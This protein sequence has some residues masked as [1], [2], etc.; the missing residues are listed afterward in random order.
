MRLRVKI[1][2]PESAGSVVDGTLQVIPIRGGVFRGEKIRGR[3][4]SRGA[5]WNTTHNDGIAH[6]FAKYLLLKDDSEN[7]AIENEGSIDS[8]SEATRRQ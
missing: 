8:R 7:I 5:D 6:V 2:K 1:S 3:V 4:V